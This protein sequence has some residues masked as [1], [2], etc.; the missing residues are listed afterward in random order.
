MKKAVKKTVKKKKKKVS[1]AKRLFK[2]IGIFTAS[3]FGFL[4]VSLGIYALCGG[5]KE[6]VVDLL[7]MKFEQAAYVLTGDSVDF[8]GVNKIVVGYKNKTTGEIFETVKLIQTNEDATKLDITLSGGTSFVTYSENNKVGS[9]LMFEILQEKEED[10][11]RGGIYSYNKGAG[12]VFVLR[13]VQDETQ[14]A[15]ETKIFIESAVQSISTK[16]INASNNFDTDKIYPG[17]TFVISVPKENIFPQNALNAPEEEYKNVFYSVYGQ[18]YFKKQI[19]YYSS[20]PE[21]ASVNALTG[22]VV[23]HK[24]GTFTITTYIAKTYKENAEVNALYTNQLINREPDSDELTQL[25]K[26]CI[27]KGDTF[28]A[29]DIEVAGITAKTD[30]SQNPLEVFKSYKYAFNGEYSANDNMLD[31]NI[32]LQKPAGADFGNVNLDYRL[33]DIQLFEG[34]MKG[35]KV[36]INPQK[37]GLTS[38]K[39]INQNVVITEHLT[40]FKN[41]NPFNFMIRVDAYTSQDIYLV[42]RI[43]DSKLEFNESDYECGGE[44]D[45][46]KNAFYAYIKISLKTNK[47]EENISFNVSKI[48][49]QFGISATKNYENDENLLYISKDKLLNLKDAD[50]FTNPK[51]SQTFN[52]VKYFVR[53]NLETDSVYL[54]CKDYYDGINPEIQLYSLKQKTSGDSGGETYF[55]YEE[56]DNGQY[57]KLNTGIDI[58]STIE[59]DIYAKMFEYKYKISDTGDY[60]YQTE[61]VQDNETKEIKEILDANG[62]KIKVVEY[63]FDETDNTKYTKSTGDQTDNLRII[64]SQ[65]ITFSDFTFEP[66]FDEQSGNK[67][68]SVN[69]GETLT[70]SFIVTNPSGLEKAIDAGLFKLNSSSNDLISVGNPVVSE[71]DG[72]GKCSISI[73][74]VKQGRGIISIL[75]NNEPVNMGG[76]NENLTQ[77]DLIVGNNDVKSI[78]FDDRQVELKPENTASLDFTVTGADGKIAFA[79]STNTNSAV[80][81]W[82]LTLNVEGGTD[83]TR[84]YFEILS[85]DIVVTTYSKGEKGEPTG[86]GKVEIVVKENLTIGDLKNNKITIYPHKLCGNL[87]FYV[88]ALIEGNQQVKSQTLSL[89][90]KEPNGFK[91]TQNINDNNKITINSTEYEKVIGGVEFNLITSGT[92]NGY[93]TMTGDENLIDVLSVENQSIWGITTLKDTTTELYSRT[94]NKFFD[95]K[96]NTIC[97][98]TFKPSYYE[99]KDYKT[100]NFYIIP[101]RIVRT[102]TV[103]MNAGAT[104]E[105]ADLQKN[106]HLWTR[107]YNSSEKPTAAYAGNIDETEFSNPTIK[108]YKDNKNKEKTEIT[109][110]YIAPNSFMGD[111]DIIYCDVQITDGSETKTYEGILNIVINSN[112]S[113]TQIRGIKNDNNNL[114]NNGETIKLTDLFKLKPNSTSTSESADGNE[115]T[116]NTVVLSMD[117]ATKLKN[118]NV[119]FYDENKTE[120]TNLTS[121]SLQKIDYLEFPQDL[122]VFEIDNLFANITAT[123]NG[124]SKTRENFE[125]ALNFKLTELTIKDADIYLLQNELENNETALTLD[126]KQNLIANFVVLAVENTQTSDPQDVK[127]YIKIDVD[128]KENGTETICTLIFTLNSIKITKTCIV[129][130]GNIIEQTTDALVIAKAYKISELF[131]LKDKT[132][133]SAFENATFVGIKDE[134]AEYSILSDSKIL[135]VKNVLLSCTLQIKMLNRTFEISGFAFNKIQASFEGTNTLYSNLEYEIFDEDN[136]KKIKDNNLAV[137][138]KITNSDNSTC[139]DVSYVPSSDGS[140]SN[141]I[142]VSN[143]KGE[144][145]EINIEVTI[146]T[147]GFVGITLSKEFILHKLI[148]TPKYDGNTYNG[149]QIL[150]NNFESNLS[151][152]FEI[153]TSNQNISLKSFIKEPEIPNYNYTPT[154]DRDT[155]INLTFKLNDGKLV[156][157]IPFY[158]KVYKLIIKQSSDIYFVGQSLSKS[159]LLALV[160]IEDTAG[161]V[162]ASEEIRQ[163]IEITGESTELVQG[164]NSF[165]VKFGNLQA[166]III[167]AVE[168]QFSDGTN[169]NVYPDTKVSRY[170]SCFVT[171]ENGKNQKYLT[172]NYKFNVGEG[173]NVS[174]SN[175]VYTLKQNSV[176]VAILNSVSGEIIIPSS[177]ESDTTFSVI[178]FIEG[179]KVLEDSSSTL[180]IISF[181]ISTAA[182][183]GNNSSQNIYVGDQEYDLSQFAKFI[184]NGKDKN[185]DFEVAEIRNSDSLDYT[186]TTNKNTNEILI[187]KNGICYAKL[188][189]KDGNRC[190]LETSSKLDAITLQLKGYLSIT[191]SEYTV[192]S[193]RDSYINLTINLIKIDVSFAG[194]TVEAEG[195][196]YYILDS[197]SN[198]QLKPTISGGEDL[199]LTEVEFSEGFIGKM[200][201]TVV[202][203]FQRNLQNLIIDKNE[204]SKVTLPNGMLLSISKPET[205]GLP[206]SFSFNNSMLVDYV[207]LTIDYCVNSI[208]NA[209]AYICLKPELNI[210][211][212]YEKDAKYAQVYSPSS[213]EVSSNSSLLSFVGTTGDNENIIGENKQIELSTGT[214]FSFDI[215]FSGAL[216]NVPD[217]L[218]ETIFSSGTDKKHTIEF[219]AVSSGYAIS[220][221]TNQ[222][223]IVD[224]CYYCMKVIITNSDGKDYN[225]YYLLKVTSINVQTKYKENGVEIFISNTNPLIISTPQTIDLLSYIWVNVTDSEQT[226]GNGPQYREYIMFNAQDNSQYSVTKSGLF[227]LKIDALEKTALT[228]TLY[229]NTY[230]FYVKGQEL[231]VVFKEN[232]ETKLGDYNF[233]KGNTKYIY[234]TQNKVSDGKEILVDVRDNKITGSALSSD[235]ILNLTIRSYEFAGTVYEDDSVFTCE[236]ND[237]SISYCFMGTPLIVL[238]RADNFYQLDISSNISGK[239]IFEL[240]P[241]YQTLS[242]QRLCYVNPD[243]S[244]DVNYINPVVYED[245][246]YQ[247]VLSGTDFDLNTIVNISNSSSKATYQIESGANSYV[248]LDENRLKVSDSLQ[249]AEYLKI[250]ISLDGVINYVY[251]KAVPT[252]ITNI[253]NNSGTFNCING[254]TINLF[255]Y[256]KIKSF[257]GFDSQNEPIYEYIT[258]FTESGSEIS[259]PYNYVLDGNK[260]IEIDG[261]TFNFKAIN[262]TL[263]NQECFIGESLDLKQIVQNTVQSS[264]LSNKD[265]TI[266]FVADDYVTTNGIFT[267]N[268]AKSYTVNV[269]INN[270]EYSLNVNVKTLSITVNHISSIVALDEE[271]KQ[272]KKY[273]NVYASQKEEDLTKFIKVSQTTTYNNKLEFAISVDSCVA[274]ADGTSYDISKF[275]TRNSNVMGLNTIVL[276]YDNLAI[277]AIGN[278]GFE[279]YQDFDNINNQLKYEVLLNISVSLV[280]N[281]AVKN[282]FNVRLLPISVNYQANVTLTKSSFVENG[283][284]LQYNLFNLFNVSTKAT[285]NNLSLINAVKFYDDNNKEIVDGL[286]QIS[287]NSSGTLLTQITAKFGGRNFTIELTC[288]LDQDTVS[289]SLFSDSIDTILNNN[290]QASI[291]GIYGKNNEFNYSLVVQDGKIYYD[292]YN[293]DSKFLFRIDSTGNIQSKTLTATNVYFIAGRTQGETYLFVE[294]KC[295]TI[296]AGNQSITFNTNGYSYVEDSGVNVLEFISGDQVGL[297]NFLNGASIVESSFAGAISG[298]AGNKINIQEVSEISYGYFDCKKGDIQ[299]R[300]YIKVYPFSLTQSVANDFEFKGAQQVDGTTVAISAKDNFVTL[301][302]TGNENINLNSIIKKVSETLLVGDITYKIDRVVSYINDSKNY[303]VFKDNNFSNFVSLENSNLKI[304]SNGTY[305]VYMS[306]SVNNQT[307]NF[308]FR[309]LSVK[310]QFSNGSFEIENNS[311]LNLSSIIKVYASVE[312]YEKSGDESEINLNNS[313]NIK[314]INS[315]NTTINSN[316]ITF[317][318]QNFEEIFETIK[319]EDGNESQVSTGK[320]GHKIEIAYSYKDLTDKV[321]ITVLKNSVVDDTGKP[322]LNKNGTL[323]KELWYNESAQKIDESVIKSALING[324]SYDAVLEKGTINGVNTTYYNI[325]NQIKIVQNTGEIWFKNPNYDKTDSTSTEYIVQNKIG[326]IYLVA[327]DETE[328]DYNTKTNGISVTTKINVLRDVNYKI[329]NYSISKSGNSYTYIVDGEQNSLAMLK[330]G[331]IL[332]NDS[333]EFVNSLTTTNDDGEEVNIQISRNSA[334][335]NCNGITLNQNS[336]AVSGTKTYNNVKMFIVAYILSDNLLLNENI[337]LFEI[338]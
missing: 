303:K 120:I 327:Q 324:I 235:I 83:S 54:V 147:S 10:K 279:C 6:K 53:K 155:T 103:E 86:N 191:S 215:D 104:K 211:F 70:I 265:A 291:I 243:V 115:A 336:G 183:I 268:V 102:D 311:S 254:E 74:A 240:A 30:L 134:K 2:T 333:G 237:N 173:D 153:S 337:V 87:Q 20:A 293:N 63:Y 113:L 161:N 137:T 226:T 36:Y 301:F 133:T 258:N 51:S 5:F 118:Y 1:F 27:V 285:N 201:P 93:L 26:L 116:I 156:A 323:Y 32:N 114:L 71:E 225:Y 214:K 297:E 231:S 335:I 162:I 253:L 284:N 126:G 261:L 300:V 99:E 154:E 242:Q 204:K 179:T 85:D 216:T 199:S 290:S 117:S 275:S 35:G 298:F 230:Y 143:Y 9:P 157:T 239:L 138:I 251:V 331:L 190:V 96:E 33:Q 45:E 244:I 15:D 68:I 125:F 229:N 310:N 4:G 185:P 315:L 247:N 209:E 206:Y 314:L 232:G 42:A 44:N 168:A 109:G 197:T 112:Y 166:S 198:Y 72:K 13:A 95:V 19:L 245:K 141:K 132:I 296:S 43:A 205:K 58:N 264:T 59:F 287:K 181:Y 176:V 220:I 196:E 24:P 106:V 319:D 97:Q 338:S 56:D 269:L 189:F 149:N 175:G 21:I 100:F 280:G 308:A 101:Q 305:Y 29:K 299:T 302:A 228:F 259:D 76:V 213:H 90:V 142:R 127:K 274:N 317:D 128:K 277:F 262:L 273:E 270:V 37:Y 146:N 263:I 75:F 84:L 67:T 330:F 294:S 119:K 255:D 140:F 23:V 164:E 121:L 326:V 123:V 46:G 207:F 177:V 221:S 108:F 82:E 170:V 31:L 194:N 163:K 139:Q 233:S 283:N 188:K 218:N 110:D 131:E 316:I 272:G 219:N 41:I 309:V 252:K 187:N 195:K 57:V 152:Y 122:N 224:D 130:N 92:T 12:R 271:T 321:S 260:T 241:N 234:F 329:N 217:N 165:E 276:Y 202:L 79:P 182:M 78:S 91:I 248:S 289:S 136:L 250:K 39:E 210:A 171:D 281:S 238:T 174:E 186:Y 52:K 159:E 307:L 222:T 129:L 223:G 212:E 266:L 107:G 16:I 25:E 227:T 94:D 332:Q 69:K 77:F 322:L 150:I 203:S 7:G 61:E 60:E 249:N 318:E 55:A 306:A 38:E 282:N 256:I 288:N 64:L 193:L 34:I 8:D 267:S 246:N 334:S 11:N 278:S 73:T 47:V 40:I 180:R 17:H 325:A 292:V 172:L 62:N 135:I 236:Y 167:S 145:K 178:A 65:N 66:N 81:S 169:F 48:M 124:T 105:L 160:Q 257:V 22:E 14:L 111:T 200:H 151:D 148:I 295:F 328:I 313:L 18:N 89:S 144:Q 49:A 320:F 88:Y 98:I 192:E 50:L 184:L 80:A 312:D 304:I 3:V 28:T 158:I 286:Y 208:Y